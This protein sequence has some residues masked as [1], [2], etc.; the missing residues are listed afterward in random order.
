MLLAS[1]PQ[2]STP[3]RRRAFAVGNA[4]FKDNWVSAP[5]SSEGRDGLGPLF[6]ARSCSACHLRDGRGAPAESPTKP[7]TGL[8]LRIGI[9]GEGGDRPHPIYG[10]QIQDQAIQGVA[11]E[12]QIGTTYERL[13]GEYA[14][15]TEFELLAPR[16]ELLET[17]YGAPGESA[18]LG[19]RVAPQMIGLGL[20]EAIPEEA[21]VAQADPQDLD[22]D[23]ISGRVH[24]IP[25]GEAQHPIVGRFGW[26]ATQGTVEQQVAAAF[27]HDI[28]ITS[29][30]H[31]KEIVTATEAE[32]FEVISGGSPELSR[33]KLQRVTFYSQV[34][35]VPDQRNPD[36]LP[37]R[38]GHEVFRAIGCHDCHRE[39]WQTAKESAISGYADVTFHPFTDL[40][41]HDMGV[42]LADAKVDGDA[43]KSEWRTPP[44]WG[45]GLVETVNGHTRFLHDGRARSLEEAILWHGGEASESADSYRQLSAAQRQDLLA[46]LNSL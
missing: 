45:I 38:R 10:V 3:W 40:L 11:A 6:N 30:L 7:N 20:L 24:W 29:D 39:T 5:A 15:G 8:L 9:P 43:Q 46:F 26:K 4:F 14:D 16:Y 2:L 31:V 22:G 1:L 37:Q 34:L 23:G 21:I 25:T 17:A 36:A 41:L 42:G 27:V 18:V 19:A 32:R 35:A 28:G 12:A 33:H 44:L 13:P